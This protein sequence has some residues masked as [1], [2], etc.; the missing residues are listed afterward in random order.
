MPT[1][2]AASVFQAPERLVV[3]RFTLANTTAGE[4]AVTIH[5]VT[6]AVGVANTGNQILPAL[7]VPANDTIVVSAPTVLEQGDRIFVLAA[8]AVNL[9]FIV[10]DRETEVL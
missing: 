5:I 1:G 2:A 4:L 8:G 9:M 3:H 10:N 7:R 6:T